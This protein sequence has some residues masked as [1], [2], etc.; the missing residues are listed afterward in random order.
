MFYFTCNHGLKEL[1]YR[2]V[3]NRSQRAVVQLWQPALDFIIVR[4]KSRTPWSGMYPV[5]RTRNVLD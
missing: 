3:Y 2:E 5:N 1:I 4:L